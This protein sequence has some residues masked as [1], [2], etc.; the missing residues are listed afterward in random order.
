[1]TQF[2]TRVMVTRRT[3]SDAPALRWTVIGLEALVAVN[4]VW[5]GITMIA[6]PWTPLGIT[7]DLIA[8]S[9]FT[10]YTWPGIL[11][12]VLNGIAP[13]TLAVALVAHRHW[14]MVWSAAWG[15]GLMAWIVAQ[16]L[17]LT[18]VLWLQYV[19]FVVGAVVAGC[20]VAAL[21]RGGR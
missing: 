2:A 15:V 19:L 18:D 3:Y 17:M 16:W 1:M 6:N 13:A 14:A 20:A 12:L 5:A 11:L 10:N 7:T 21:R 8:G 4:A 9:P